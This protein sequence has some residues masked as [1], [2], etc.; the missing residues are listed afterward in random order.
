[1]SQLFS[2]VEPTLSDSAGGQFL[3]VVL[4]PELV[5]RLH[6]IVS[7]SH[8]IL[9]P[10]LPESWINARNGDR[11]GLNKYMQ[12]SSYQLGYT[13]QNFNPILLLCLQNT[14]SCPETK[15]NK[16]ISGF[17]FPLHQAPSFSNWRKKYCHPA[18]MVHH[19]F[20]PTVTLFFR[21]KPL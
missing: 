15:K 4:S 16:P 2:I 8:Q 17:S 1:M 5:R 7:L 11:K 13:S 20:L 18:Q 12:S 6:Q 14:S 19:Y 3:L 10:K 21:L 9:P